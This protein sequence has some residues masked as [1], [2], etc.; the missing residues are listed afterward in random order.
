[1]NLSESSE[2]LEVIYPIV[3]NR[4]MDDQLLIARRDE[5][6][7]AG[8]PVKNILTHWISAHQMFLNDAFQ[9]GLV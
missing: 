3:I 2:F 1:M 7:L 5:L 8:S 9:F 6:L 4:V